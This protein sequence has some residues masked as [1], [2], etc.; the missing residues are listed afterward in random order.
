[1][2]RGARC[3]PA[4]LVVLVRHPRL[5]PLSILPS[6][7]VGAFFLGGLVSG[8]LLARTLGVPFWAR[9][10]PEP[11]TFVVRTTLWLA[12]VTSGM[13][14]G[15]GAGL[16]LMAPVLDRLSQR[17][18]RIIRGGVAGSALGFGW[19]LRQSAVA[20]F[21]FLLAAPG[22]FL[23]GII[24]FLGPGLGVLWGAHALAL[25]ETDGPLARRG[26]TFAARRAW[27]RRFRAESLGFGL[28]SLTPLLAFPLNVVLAP[29]VAP[30]ITAGATLLV[31]TLD[32]RAADPEGAAPD[33]RP[34]VASAATRRP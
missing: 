28:V 6:L 1:M 11:V 12:V 7:L 13:I 20:A 34:V 4:G 3:L 5:W 30:S 32:D 9:D 31:L 26:L 33:R 10:L 14:L 18:E 23:L 8:G 21:Y 29:L 16:L 25:Q 2:G 19:E 15:F 27:H 22:V 24:P 17:I